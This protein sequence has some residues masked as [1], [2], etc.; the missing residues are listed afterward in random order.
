MRSTELSEVAAAVFADSIPEEMLP[1]STSLNDGSN[2]DWNNF[3]PAVK[4]K[5]REYLSHSSS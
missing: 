5:V 3:P 1:Y 4:R 2:N